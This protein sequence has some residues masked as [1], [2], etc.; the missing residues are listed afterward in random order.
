MAISTFTLIAYF[1]QK[2]C[3]NFKIVHFRRLLL[4]TLVGIT[5]INYICS[6]NVPITTTGPRIAAVILRA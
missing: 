5:F 4:P 2:E 3:F 1:C 6:P